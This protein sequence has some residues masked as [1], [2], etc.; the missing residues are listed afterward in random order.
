MTIK[1]TTL[2][3]AA[4]CAFFLAA[5]VLGGSVY[6]ANQAVGSERTA[7]ARQAEFRS[8]AGEL[9]AASDFLTNKARQFSVTQDKKHLDDYWNEI[10]V[11][12]T[13][14]RVVSRLGELGATE[15][16]LGLIEQ[17]KANSDALV[18]TESR[19]MRLVLEALGT[20]EAQ[21]PPAIAGYKLSP[22]DAALSKDEKLATAR[23]IMFDNKY[24]ADK[25]IIVGPI[26]QFR[27]Q[28]EA[29]V[30]GDVSGARD[31]TR[32][33]ITVLV[34]IA[35]A[36]PVIAFTVV[37]TFHKQ[38]SQPVATHRKKLAARS[39]TDR[40]FS[41]EPAGTVELRELATAFN[42]LIA[43]NQKHASENQQLVSGMSQLVA[44]IAEDAR[45][46]ASVASELSG[47]SDQMAAASG[48]IATAINEVTRS[49]TT[50]ASLSQDSARD[51]E[52]VAGASRELAA[53]ASSSAT[54]ADE[55]RQEASRIG[56]QI[57]GVAQASQEL[58]TAAEGS[59]DAALRGQQA[60]VQ[61]VS[62]MES[63]AEAVGRASQTVDQ[64]GHYGQQIG[65]IVRAIDEIAAQTNLLALNAAIEA[66]RAGE[67]GRGFAVVAENVRHLAERSSE[68][69]KE[70]AD[71][72]ARVQASTTEAVEVMA[73]GV[74]DVEAGRSIT[75]EA[76]N[77][78]ESI[79]ESVQQSA[80]QMQRIAGEVGILAAGADRIVTSA[81]L[82][83]THAADSA[84]GAKQMAAGTT[85]VTDAIMQ[86]SATSEQTSASAEEVSA[87]TQELSAQSEELAAT[88]NQMMQL[89]DSLQQAV[90]KFEAS[91]AA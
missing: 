69:T 89:A 11:T 85:R 60:V 39:A 56:A 82:I 24:D 49:A 42:G 18:G 26:T 14:D 63:I 30:A 4:A 7:L 17:A 91:Q 35:V 71:L 78:L 5:V 83:A 50:L 22:A 73:D 31:S 90:A 23:I 64:L 88:A 6:F 68:S 61:A 44:S 84:A 65:D 76:G 13:R 51:V 53:S 34:I 75:A 62:A 70:I 58:A 45:S 19:S 81:E 27:T 8:L 2:S 28:M 38:V 36:V 41:L 33:A 25:A 79:I 67:Q 54:A 66:A 87:S 86:V 37:G 47:S 59:R 16:E 52:E 40:A 43:D 46:V 15:K 57:Q 21:M 10:N 3:I 77:A 74:K 72:I 32:T 80:T 29:R 20:P 55:A 48:Q 1:Q 9:G 12:K